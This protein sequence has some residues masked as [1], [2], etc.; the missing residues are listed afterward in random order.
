MVLF[1]MSLGDKANSCIVET[2]EGL[3]LTVHVIPKSSRNQIIFVNDEILKLKITS[4]PVDG[5]ANEACIA[6]LSD[7]LRVAKSRIK[8]VSGLKSKNKIFDI[9]GSTEVLLEAFWKVA[10]KDNA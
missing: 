7:I 10:I 3:R 4:P 1:I 2:S 6:F 8:L 9:S 5:K